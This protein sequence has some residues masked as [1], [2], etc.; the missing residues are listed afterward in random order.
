M[1]VLIRTDTEIPVFG[2]INNI[3]INEDQ[4]MFLTCKVDTL[5]FDYHFN[6][7]CDEERTDSVSVISLKDLI[8]YIPYDKQFSN[9]MDEK[10][11]IV[12]HCHI[13]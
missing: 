10:T 12:P 1:F 5:Y 9:E 13:V 7:Y 6:A 2:K 4:A 11:Y 8:Y 3:I